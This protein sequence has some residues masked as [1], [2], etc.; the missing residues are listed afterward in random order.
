MVFT[1]YIPNNSATKF[2]CSTSLPT[3]VISCLFENNHSN[4]CE[5]TSHFGFDLCFLDDYLHWGPFNIPFGHLFIFFGENIYP[6]RLPS[7]QSRLFTFWLNCFTYFCTIKNILRKIEIGR[8]FECF[9]YKIKHS[10]TLWS[11]II[12]SIYSKGAEN[13]CA[14]K[15]L[16]MNIYSTLF[17]IA[18]A[19]KQ[20]RCSSVGKWKNKLWYIQMMEYY[21][22]LKRNDL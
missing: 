21:T 7:F 12:L 1:I 13:L 16:H 11:I 22:A 19:W 4:K 10:L 8:Q 5:I 18:K 20:P 2:S 9:F 6:D 17:I 3:L 15:S 14:L